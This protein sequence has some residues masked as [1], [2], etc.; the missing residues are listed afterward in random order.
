[1]PDN[2]ENTFQSYQPDVAI[3]PALQQLLKR[4]SAINRG[5]QRGALITF[6]YQFMKNDPTPLVLITD[7]VQ[8]TRIRGINLHYITLNSMMRLLAN[9]GNSPAFSYRSIMGDEHISNA[10][11][12]YKW[13]GV[14]T[15]LILDIDFI[16]QVIKVVQMQHAIKPNE[17]D[18]IIKSV[19][20]QLNN[21]TN[22]Q[23][24]DLQGLPEV[25]E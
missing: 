13:Q 2:F 4:P 19:E 6:R 1:M 21:P 15:P 23:A 18:A 8:G 5:I 22:P 14:I 11:R 9:F 7:F 24:G 16:K 10:F 20:Q 12:Y 25:Q 17:L 3:N